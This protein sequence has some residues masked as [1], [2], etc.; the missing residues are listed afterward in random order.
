MA[1]DIEAAVRCEGDGLL[2]PQLFLLSFSR[3]LIIILRFILYELLK[4]A[5]VLPSSETARTYSIKRLIS[6]HW[7]MYVY[8]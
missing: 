1:N 5:L 4:K 2:L 6:T 7:L 8:Y 3:S